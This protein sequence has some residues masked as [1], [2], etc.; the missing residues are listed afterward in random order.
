M[1]IE[2]IEVVVDQRIKGEYEPTEGS[3]PMALMEAKPVEWAVEDKVM[4]CWVS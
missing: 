3:L 4:D 2:S 1:R